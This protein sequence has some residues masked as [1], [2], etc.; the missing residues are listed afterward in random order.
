VAGAV[1]VTALAD[2]AYCF[3]SSTGKIIGLATGGTSP[4]QFSLD[5]INY[6]NSD[7]FS[8]VPIGNYTV[9]VKDAGGCSATATATVYQPDSLYFVSITTT[10]V[11]CPGEKNGTI[12]VVAGGGTPP[13]NYSCTKDLV[14]FIYTVNGVLEGLDTGTYTIILSDNNGCTRTTTAY[15]PGPVVDSFIVTTDS[16]SCYGSQ[17]KDGAVIVTPQVFQNA[18]F[19]YSLNGGTSQSSDTFSNVG[20][21]IYTVTAVNANGCTTTLAPV[22]VGQPGQRWAMALPQDTTLQL[23]QSIQLQSYLYGGDVDPIISYSWSPFQGLSCADCQ[24]PIASPYAEVNP[25]TV[26]ITYN[27]HCTADASLVIYVT[28]SGAVWAPDAFTPNGD[29]NNDI[30][31]LYGYG[32]REV[33]L[34]I[35]NRWGEKV[36]ESHDQFWG[37]DGTYKGVLQNPAV[38]VYEANV[39][40]L[41]GK[42]KFLKGSVTLIR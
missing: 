10:A 25:Y 32:I 20:A 6:Q 11:K 34:K 5:G 8:G 16:T 26:T 37:W 27:G 40:F 1:S 22:T 18:P 31:Y 12:T 42:T 17:W 14:S 19:S 3:G 30:F 41:D 21:G 9:T 24:N 36:F 2:S 29:G 28:L 23:G 15:V 33:N 38:F 4:Y 13:Y 7:T 35:F 39:T